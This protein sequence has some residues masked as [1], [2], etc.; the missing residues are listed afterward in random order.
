MGSKKTF[1]VLDL[2]MTLIYSTSIS[3]DEAREHSKDKNG[4]IM[5]DSNPIGIS[6]VR[7]RKHLDHFINELKKRGIR[8]IVW[9]A[10]TER[11]VKT[12]CEI[13]FGRDTLEHVLTR[14][15]YDKHGE[16]KSIGVIEKCN[17]VPGFSIDKAV[18]IDDSVINGEHYPNHII[19]VKQFNGQEDDELLR[20][21]D[22]L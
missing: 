12:L 7:K 19:V 15:D 8:L 1:V 2:D 16:R 21:L 11:Y 6:Y 17:L 14:I 4:F 10:G 18:L 20:V 13:I 3:E 22:L 9:S 5:S